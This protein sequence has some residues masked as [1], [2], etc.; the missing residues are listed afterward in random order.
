M[1]WLLGVNCGIGIFLAGWHA[2]T[3][4]CDTN[5]EKAGVVLMCITFVIFGLAAIVFDLLSYILKETF[6]KL[7]I[8]SW[9][10]LYKGKFDNLDEYGKSVTLKLWEIHKSDWNPFSKFWLKEVAKRNGIRL[11]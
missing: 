9:I 6:S 2:S 11:E 1:Y 10:S 8:K 4:C 7:Q 5:R 3:S